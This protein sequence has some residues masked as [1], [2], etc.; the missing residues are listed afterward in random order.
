V[1][2]SQNP[3]VHFY[4]KVSPLQQQFKLSLNAVL[5]IHGPDLIYFHRSKHFYWRLSQ[6]QYFKKQFTVRFV[7][8]ITGSYT[9]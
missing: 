8:K 2:A 9:N 5:D 4:E 6:Q 1:I 3:L 7:C